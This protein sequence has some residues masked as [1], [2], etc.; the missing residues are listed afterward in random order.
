MLTN[1]ITPIKSEEDYES[2]LAE[3]ARLMDAEPDTPEGDRLDVLTTLVEAYEARHWPIEPP[4]PIEAIRM[5]MEQR[6]LRPK[7]L[8]PYFGSRARAS[9]VLNRKRALT[10]PMIRRLSQGLGIPATTL[11]R[12]TRQESEWEQSARKTPAGSETGS[13]DPSKRRHAPGDA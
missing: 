13:P 9:E 5:R 1:P 11:I 2:A 3:I 6:G 12:E 10:L 4:D 8:E 7:D